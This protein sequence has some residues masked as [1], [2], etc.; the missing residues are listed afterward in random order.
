VI[1]PVP[2]GMPTLA[3]PIPTWSEFLALIPIA[4]SCFVIIVAQSAATARSFGLLHRERVDEDADLLG[5]AAANAAAALS[6][7]FVV[8]G[9]PTQTAMAER[10]GARSQLAQLVFAG[11]VLL[12]LLFLT[13]PLAY[14][15][16]AVLAAIVFTIALGLVD[17]RNLRAIRAES[18]GEFRVA[19]VTAAV[20]ALAGVEQGI[21]LAVV[22]SLLRHV[23]HS[24]QPHTAIRAPDAS[25]RW[26]T[27]PATPGGETAPGLIVY[28][29]GADLF[30][31]N[32]SRFA[33]EVRALVTHAPHPVRRFVVDAAAITDLDYSAARTLADLHDELAHRGVM[34]V[35][36]RVSPSLRADMNRHG[37]T[38]K[39]GAA[40]V[41]ATLHE[42]LPP[43][44][45]PS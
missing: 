15:P 1:G 10:V 33:D 11:I 44:A 28:H 30:Y 21:L 35:F 9:S 4:A 5:L 16:H 19:I 32:D 20:V 29:F 27:V 8:N 45:P 13:A 24:Y 22:L 37:L 12:V 41:H 43:S 23:R 40:Q 39:I 25:G 38:M 17:W 3:L 7:A 34:L 31:A 14:L 18:R 26:E 36:G 6:G 2:G 42:A